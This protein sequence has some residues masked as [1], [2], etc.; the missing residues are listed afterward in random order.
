MMRPEKM[1]AWLNELVE[2]GENIP[3]PHTHEEYLSGWDKIT[4]DEVSVYDW[5]TESEIAFRSLFE[6][7]QGHEI[8]RSWAGL[9]SLSKQIYE[10]INSKKWWFL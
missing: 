10:K 8:N 7:D 1:V 6:F 3:Q 4:Y 5:I 9:V 2:K